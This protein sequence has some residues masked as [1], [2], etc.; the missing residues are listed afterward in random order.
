MKLSSSAL[1]CLA[2]PVFCLLAAG[3]MSP[4]SGVYLILSGIGVMIASIFSW[5]GSAIMSLSF[6]VKP[7][8]AIAV[9]V[10][11]FKIKIF[12]REA[13]QISAGDYVCGA[14][15]GLSAAVFMWTQGQGA[16]LA[17][18]MGF[19]ISAVLF[20][21]ANQ[22]ESIKEKPHELKIFCSAAFVVC[23]SLGLLFFTGFASI[24]KSLEK[25]EDNLAE[26]NQ[27]VGR[28]FTTHTP[29]AFAE[30]KRVAAEMVEEAYAS[31]ETPYRK[32][33][34]LLE[35]AVSAP[36]APYYEDGEVVISELDPPFEIRCRAGNVDE[37]DM[38]GLTRAIARGVCAERAGLIK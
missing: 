9:G 1:V 26:Y 11:I 32:H 29:E 20:K 8:L 25:A 4:G 2:I 37:G 3:L 30:D 27:A 33:I 23:A 6:L 14:V 28:L 38:S 19:F 34:W 10:L 13:S 24:N 18:S 31:Y 5:I 35:E 22:D 21:S 15:A 17:M 36:S 16:I 7:I 12:G